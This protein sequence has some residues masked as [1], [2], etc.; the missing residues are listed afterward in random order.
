MFY[1]YNEQGNDSPPFG[2]REDAENWAREHWGMR[3]R[4]FGE[5]D[6]DEGKVWQRGG[7]WIIDDQPLPEHDKV[8]SGNVS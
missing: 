2:K 6:E 4:Q 3:G 5:K 7:W 1:A 8:P